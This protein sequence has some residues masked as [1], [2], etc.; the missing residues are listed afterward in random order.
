MTKLLAG[1][2]DSATSTL[3]DMLLAKQIAEKLME[4]YPHPHLWAVTCEGR[5]GIATI[6]NMNLSGQ[7]GYV[8]KLPKLYSASSLA[9]DVVRAGGEILERF[10][11]N[12]GRFNEQQYAELATNHAGDFLFEK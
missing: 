6:K 1:M 7:Y 12:R 11:M 9:K 10:G 3:N 8:L 4:H 2:D 5:T